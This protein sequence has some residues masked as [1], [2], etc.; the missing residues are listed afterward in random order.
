MSGSPTEPRRPAVADTGFLLAVM[1]RHSPQHSDSLRLYDKYPGEILVPSVVFAELTYMLQRAGG[2]ALVVRSIRAIRDSQISLIDL[3]DVDY[4]RALAILEKYSDTRIDFVDASI[5]ALAER[6]TVTRI[7][8][9]DRRDFGL[10]QP[11][12]APHFDLLP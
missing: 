10:Y 9:F 12:H 1:D 11:T 4:E 6:L 7:L 8:T 5:M 2:T 3:I